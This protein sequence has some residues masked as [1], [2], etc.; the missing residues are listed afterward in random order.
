MT[1]DE[2]FV[3][4][5][6]TFDVIFIDGLH[7]A[8]QV[9]KDIANSKLILNNN[10]KIILHDTNPESEFF[11][12]EN[13]YHNNPVFPGWNGTVWK[14]IYDH[15]MTFP[16]TYFATYP[17]DHGLTVISPH[18]KDIM[19]NVVFNKYYSY[20][21]FDIDRHNVLNITENLDIL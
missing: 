10:G 13:N 11:C 21:I 19:P 8:E 5:K 7:L 6:D 16:T 4:N 2:F 1:S 12:L 3:C 17:H 14:A 18:K 20:H 15:R 9:E